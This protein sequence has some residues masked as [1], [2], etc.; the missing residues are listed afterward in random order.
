MA[1]RWGCYDMDVPK[2]ASQ[3][4]FPLRNCVLYAQDVFTAFTA[5]LSSS[6]SH[7]IACF[8]SVFSGFKLIRY[9]RYAHSPR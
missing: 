6:F 7:S 4:F 1:W 3:I 2:G 8:G 5:F 9:H